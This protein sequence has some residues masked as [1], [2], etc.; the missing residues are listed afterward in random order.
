MG[1]TNS[2]RSKKSIPFKVNISYKMNK[3]Q[4]KYFNSCP[5]DLKQPEFLQELNYELQLQNLIVI[6]DHYAT[7]TFNYNGVDYTV[8]IRHDFKSDKYILNVY[9]KKNDYFHLYINVPIYNVKGWHH[10]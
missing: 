2:R 10:N 6:A 4:I 5:Y 1:N 3:E 8:D 9:I 7:T